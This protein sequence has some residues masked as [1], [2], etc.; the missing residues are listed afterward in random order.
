M[1]SH[2]DAVKA[3]NAGREQPFFKATTT[4]AALGKR[5]IVYILYTYN[6]TKQ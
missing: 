1:P 5:K 6:F 4:P 2:A 3:A